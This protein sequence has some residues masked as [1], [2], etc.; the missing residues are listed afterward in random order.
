MSEEV[1][2]VA[3]TLKRGDIEFVE[4]VL[5]RELNR[6][7]IV[8]DPVRGLSDHLKEGMA[9]DLQVIDAEIERADKSL[10][11]PVTDHGTLA[12]DHYSDVKDELVDKFI[13][14]YYG[15]FLANAEGMLSFIAAEHPLS[16]MKF[17][18]ELSK[19]IL[20]KPNINKINSDNQSINL[21]NFLYQLKKDVNVK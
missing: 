7:G 13:K 18:V 3:T 14:K 1:F 16:Y 5:G 20:T 17:L 11:F 10:K 2:R 15:H 19:Q 8:E 12:T 4:R 21:G 6:E 9:S